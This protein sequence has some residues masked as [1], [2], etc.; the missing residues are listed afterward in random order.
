M[1]YDV[2][3]CEND[4]IGDFGVKI[5]PDGVVYTEEVFLSKEIVKDSKIKMITV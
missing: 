2:G 4:V 1:I 5:K 3:I